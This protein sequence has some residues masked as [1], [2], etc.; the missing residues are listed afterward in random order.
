MVDIDPLNQSD[1][2]TV[3][4]LV[5]NHL[6][7]TSSPRARVILDQWPHTIKKFVKVFPQ[8]YKKVLGQSKQTSVKVTEEVSRG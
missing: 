8:D 6:R 1:E 4:R 2:E 5:E 3:K 7:Y